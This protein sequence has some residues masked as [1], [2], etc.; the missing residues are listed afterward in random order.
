ML[1][2]GA[3]YDAAHAYRTEDV[4]FWTSFVSVSTRVLEPACRTGRIAIP[5]ARAGASVTAVDLP[6]PYSRTHKPS[7][8]ARLNVGPVAVACA[9][10]RR[11][12]WWLVRF[13]TSG[14]LSRA[15]RR[16]SRPS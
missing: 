8:I 14:C 3:H 9:V 7:P 1:T 5:L 15:F 2:D 6:P 10:A 16:P 12:T 13:V 11:Y 4:R